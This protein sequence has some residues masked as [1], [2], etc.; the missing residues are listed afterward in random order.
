VLKEPVPVVGITELGD[1]SVNI[2]IKPW[3]SV[4]DFGPAI[5]EINQAILEQFGARAIQMPFPQQ[6]VRLLNDNLVVG[7]GR[8]ETSQ[9]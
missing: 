6:E 4:A 5:A 8:R 2:A 7:A 3:V 1:Y 9:P